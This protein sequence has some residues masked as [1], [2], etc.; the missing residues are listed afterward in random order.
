M[1][2]KIAD[3]SQNWE[4]PPKTVTAVSIKATSSGLRT[5]SPKGGKVVY[6]M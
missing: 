4:T 3:V 1:R 6:S 5:A 2:L